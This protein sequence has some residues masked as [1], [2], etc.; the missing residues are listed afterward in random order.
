MDER[1]EKNYLIDQTT[2]EEV[3]RENDS[4]FSYYAAEC[5]PNLF[6]GRMYPWHWHIYVQFFYVLEGQ[7]SYQL[8]SGIY[9]F[10]KGDGGFI[11]SN[12]L[13]MIPD[14]CSRN[15]RFIEELFYPAFIGGIARNDIMT[16]YVLPVVEDSAFDVFKLEGYDPEHR[17]ILDMLRE[18]YEI[19]AGK[20]E[21]YEL[22][23]HSKVTF[24]WARFYQLTGKYRNGQ[25]STPSSG[26]L[27]AMLLY[28]NEHYTEKV[29]LGQIA[30]AGACSKRECNRV[31][32]SQLHVTPFQYL[33]QIRMNKAASLLSNTNAPVTLISENCGFSDSS[34]FTKAFKAQY[35]ITPKEYRKHR[36]SEY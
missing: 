11:N 28:I 19:Y 31:F 36:K 32:Q 20:E 23:T 29:A 10:Q 30:E 25:R 27:K 1:Y 6:P 7:V 3:W 15:A 33:S 9:T 2:L 16:H 26:R 14:K 35:G 18:A 22:L 24:L 12:V 34:H 4:G 17:E 13:H 21:C 5:N 8:Q